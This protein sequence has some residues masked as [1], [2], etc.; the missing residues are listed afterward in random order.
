VLAS[1]GRWQNG[2]RQFNIYFPDED[3]KNKELFL[4]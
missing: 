1:N 3:I 4:Q 2:M